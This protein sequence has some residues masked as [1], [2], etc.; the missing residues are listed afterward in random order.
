[1]SFYGNCAVLGYYVGSSGTTTCGI[2]TQKSAFLSY[3]A[4]EA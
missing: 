4:A 3:F 2:I 1:M